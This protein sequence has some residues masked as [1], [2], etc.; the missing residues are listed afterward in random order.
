MRMNSMIS[1]TTIIGHHIVVEGLTYE[2]VSRR[3]KNRRV[4]R[5]L[6]NTSGTEEI[7]IYG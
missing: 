1:D 2:L 5:K 6:V 7:T 4:L 3:P